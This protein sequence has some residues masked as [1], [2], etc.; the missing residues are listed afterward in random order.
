MLLFWQQQGLRI[1]GQDPECGGHRGQEGRPAV[2]ASGRVSWCLDVHH[3]VPGRTDSRGLAG[4][5]P[6]KESP[7][8]QPLS[9]PAV[10]PATLVL[11]T[12]AANVLILCV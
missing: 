3:R 5:S 10:S 8:Y 2:A 6:T 9:V 1:A 11:W 7:P 4:H 12:T